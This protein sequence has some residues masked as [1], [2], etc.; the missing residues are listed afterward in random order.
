MNLGL[1]FKVEGSKEY[2]I[3]IHIFHLC[4][5]IFFK[6]GKDSLVTNLLPLKP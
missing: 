6:F 1:N 3:V 4:L 2:F 5:Y